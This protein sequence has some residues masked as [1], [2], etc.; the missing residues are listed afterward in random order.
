MLVWHP[1]L[2]AFEWARAAGPK[3]P[4]TTALWEFPTVDDDEA[5]KLFKDSQT[6]H[7]LHRTPLGLPRG[8]IGFLSDS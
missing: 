6:P 2:K 5:V 7:G 4:L 8:S 3:Q 1:V